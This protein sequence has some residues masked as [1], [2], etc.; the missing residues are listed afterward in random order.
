MN[1]IIRIP[2]K[3]RS[4]LWWLVAQVDFDYSRI[5]IADHE[6]TE[7]GITI[8]LEDKHNF[9]NTLDECLRLNISLKQFARLIKEEGLNSYEAMK[10]HTKKKFLYKTRV[11]INEAIGWYM[12]DANLVEQGWAR[13][14]LLKQLLTQL[15]ET[16]L[17]SAHNYAD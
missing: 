8:W 4:E 6:T 14:A 13:E 11:L 17:Y 16:E 12:N 7:D 9:K 10:M 15:I 5:T 3:L 2:Q 1:T